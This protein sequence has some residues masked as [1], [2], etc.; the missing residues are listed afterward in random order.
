MLMVLAKQDGRRGM[1]RGLGLG[2]AVT[3]PS[4]SIS[5]CVYDCVRELFE[6][7][8]IPASS[9]S[10]TLVA[11]GTA[12]VAGSSVTFPLDVLR[13]RLQVMGMCSDVPV[14]SWLQEARHIL[15]SE[16]IPGFF[17]GL[18]PE[19]AKVFPAVAITF[20]TFEELQ[21]CLQARRHE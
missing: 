1:F 17:R 5:F 16:G 12:G 20:L 13:R 15:F 19:V 2:L 18:F 21:L 14:R 11:G 3:I 10:A 4:V 8:G 6:A 7:Q 9:F